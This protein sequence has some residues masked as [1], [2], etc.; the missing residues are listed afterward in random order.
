[1]TSLRL[2][3]SAVF[4]IIELRQ[5]LLRDSIILCDSLLLAKCSIDCLVDVATDGLADA[6]QLSAAETQGGQ[7]ESCL[8]EC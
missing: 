5:S 2:R 6:L 3:V 1:M 8:H 4:A 7:L